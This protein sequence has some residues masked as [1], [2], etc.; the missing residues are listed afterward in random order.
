MSNNLWLLLSL[1]ALAG[2]VR[3]QDY[4]YQRPQVPF[5]EV[6]A[7][8]QQPVKYVVQT[9][10]P[11]SRTYDLESQLAPAIYENHQTVHVRGQRG[12]QSKLGYGYQ[13]AQ[14]Q[15][16]V[17][18]QQLHVQQQQQF[19]AP[20][21]H[22]QYLA[23]QRVQ[24]PQL[25][26]STNA[27]PL[28]GSGSYQQY[29]SAVA[30]PLNTLALGPPAPPLSYYH[31]QTQTQTQVQAQPQTQVQAQPQTQVQAQYGVP[32]QQNLAPQRLYFANPHPYAMV[33]LPSG[34][35]VLD[36]GH[37][38][39]VPP[40]GVL[41]TLL[42]STGL[43]EPEPRKGNQVAQSESASLD[44]YDYKQTI[45]GDTREYQRYVT[46][47]QPNGQC[48]QQILSP[49]QVDPGHKQLLQD[50]RAVAH[51]H[52]EGCTKS[53]VVYVPPGALMNAQGQL[54]PRNRRTYERR[55]ELID[56]HPFN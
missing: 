49:G 34:Q 31:P 6:S 1:L 32:Q 47:C 33:R 38:S 18:P 2:T 14:Q 7:R 30:G 8:R 46:N 36:A 40:T 5:S 25:Q 54:R 15:L 37:G 39:G 29:S 28:L 52:I 45:P 22:M 27:N 19:V 17:Q 24:Q 9:L 11:N 4:H 44:G 3:S 48:Q 42:T 50:I 16:L 23:P 53:P 20:Q 26:Y 43:T 35:Q 13:S 12:Q 21:Q 55:E 41:N 51:A 56:R 10:G